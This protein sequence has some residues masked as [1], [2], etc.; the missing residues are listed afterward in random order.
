MPYNADSAANSATTERVV[1]P[2]ALRRPISL[3]LWETIDDMVVDTPTSVSASTTAETNQNSV[4]SMAMM[5]RFDEVI[6]D[7]RCALTPSSPSLIASAR[8]S[9]CPS[10]A[11]EANSMTSGPRS[12]ANAT[13]SSTVA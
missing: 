3:R 7:T 12:P 1:A 13:M 10:S 6:R 9:R 11:C 2:S 8:A 5:R 4:C